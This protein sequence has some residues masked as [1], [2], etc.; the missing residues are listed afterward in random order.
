MDMAVRL[1][2]V[3]VKYGRQVAL[4]LPS[5]DI[6]AGGIHAL[7][8]GNGSGKSTLL[9]AIAGLERPARGRVEVFGEDLYAAE[10]ARRLELVRRM[11]LSFQKPYLFSTSVRANIEY[12]LRFRSLT[13]EEK[14]RRVDRAVA[15]LGLAGL[16]ERNARALSGGETQ[17][18]ALARALVLEPSLVLL[19]EP[20]ASVDQVHKGHVLDAIAALARGGATVLVATHWTTQIRAL[21]S[22]VIRLDGGRAAPPALENLFEGEIVAGA[23]GT[24]LM[25]SDDVLLPLATTLRGPVRAAIDP[26]EV[27]LS[28]QPP[29]DASWCRRAQIKG[30]RL[31]DDTVFVTVDAGVYLRAHVPADEFRRLNPR[32][33]D[34][35]HVTIR[36][37]GIS[38]Y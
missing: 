24:F 19:D 11:T 35:L 3:V 37:A 32:L 13:E 26:T 28:T 30:L 20:V 5:L 36:P 7:V 10:G 6:A 9:R 38:V 23:E 12:G 15:L 14:E 18:V 27:S 25:L 2:D 8:G 31:S 4:D 33:D 34:R 1:V 21:S 17:R 16:M 29:A 22:H